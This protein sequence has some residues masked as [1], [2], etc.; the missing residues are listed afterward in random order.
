MAKQE[1]NRGPESG[2]L[3]TIK[4]LYS[5]LSVK[6][7]SIA[8]HILANPAEAVHPS[9]DQLADMIGIS[10]STLVR[11][12]RKLGYNGYQRFRIALATETVQPSS[13]VYETNIDPSGD[14]ID[15]VFTNA[16][17]TLSLTKHLINHTMVERA[18]EMMFHGRRI[19][20]FGI[21]GSNIIALD[22]FHKFIRLGL[23]C[24]IADDYHMQLMLA[25]Q[26]KSDC[27]AL[28]FSHTGTNMD[29]LAIAEELKRNDCT[30]VVVTNGGRSTLAR[31]AD[32][33]LPVAVA[34]TS[35][36]SEAFTSRIAQLLVVD[37]LYVALAKLLGEESVEHIEA[38]RNTIA[39]RKT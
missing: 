2:C 12:V 28:V 36:I 17:N 7:R 5:S 13:R 26:T 29:T 19:L 9:I 22:A 18:A 3:Y 10:E 11:F 39:K 25:S 33:V 1:R 35:Y 20:I 24:V 37:L 30:V 34:S 21:G 31:M 16:M 14:D 15:L 6:E 4:S 32:V 23:D 8:D 27:V 38:M